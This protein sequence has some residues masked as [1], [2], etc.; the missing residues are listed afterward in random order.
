MVATT[1]S[2]RLRIFTHRGVIQIWRVKDRN[3]CRSI[4]TGQP[5]MHIKRKQMNH[6]KQRWG[7]KESIIK[8]KNKNVMDASVR[9]PRQKNCSQQS[10]RVTLMGIWVWLVMSHDLFRWRC[11]HWP[12][13]PLQFVL[14]FRLTG[15]CGNR[16]PLWVFFSL[17]T[18]YRFV[19]C[20]LVLWSISTLAHV[21]GGGVQRER[22]KAQGRRWIEKFWC[23]A[24]NPPPVLQNSKYY[25]IECLM[26]RLHWTAHHM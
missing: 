23:Y 11:L 26:V 21:K 22:E 1:T 6:G 3:A 24:L 16:R 7:K 13:E 2:S 19:W 25:L 5:G 9:K 15:D 20:V 12:W 4:S 17:L 10:V 18:S 8:N 14:M